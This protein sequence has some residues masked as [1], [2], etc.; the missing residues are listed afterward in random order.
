MGLLTKSSKSYRSAPLGWPRQS[1]SLCPCLFYRIQVLG[2]SGIIT[3]CLDLFGSSPWSLLQSV[4]ISLSLLHKK[5]PP[6]LCYTSYWKN[7]RSDCYNNIWQGGTRWQSQLTN[8]MTV[9]SQSSGMLPL[10]SPLKALN[11]WL[12]AACIQLNFNY[13]KLSNINSKDKTIFKKKRWRVIT[14]TM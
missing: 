8:R 6:T 11:E 5:I 9:P 10:S 4:L 2:C 14:F 7:G 1:E 12:V 13:Y 3:F